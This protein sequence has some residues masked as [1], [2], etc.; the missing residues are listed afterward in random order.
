MKRKVI[1]ISCTA[2][3][4][5]ASLFLMC[6]LGPGTPEQN[7]AANTV[8]GS[9]YRQAEVADSLSQ[10]DLPVHPAPYPKIAA[11]TTCADA[12][13]NSEWDTV[14]VA[15]IGLAVDMTIYEI[16]LCIDTLRAVNPSVKILLA[17]VIPV[18]DMTTRAALYLLNQ[19]IACLVAL[20]NTAAS[21][22]ILVDQW[23]GFIPDSV[24][25]D[26]GDKV[27]PN[28][29]GAD[30]MAAK[31]FEAL[32]PLLNSTDTTRVWPLGNS[33]TA[34][35][36]G[37]ATY[38]RYLYKKLIEAQLLF[39]FVGNICCPG[40]PSYELTADSCTTPKEN[41]DHEPEDYD[42]NHDG[43]FNWRVEWFLREWA[44]LGPQYVDRQGSVIGYY[45]RQVQPDI[46]LMHIGHNDIGAALR[47]TF[48][49]YSEL[50]ALMTLSV[51]KR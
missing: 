28:M 47:D 37:Y 19:H 13:A 22:I 14:D 6:T 23:N 11:D 35:T 29:W 20:K 24:D 2:V 39:D 1:A 5:C 12:L 36:S 31:W 45:A 9:G 51:K 46:V 10:D 40:V 50:D 42:Y 3:L 4:V 27:H 44:D 38:R 16:G 18:V 48:V 8:S 43:H 32:S 25:G 21:P 33:I 34:G 26:L 30:K 15:T 49:D 17:Q 41:G 7:D